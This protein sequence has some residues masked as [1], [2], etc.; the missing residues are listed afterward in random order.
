[1]ILSSFDLLFL[2]QITSSIATFMVTSLNVYGY[3]YN[4]DHNSTGEN[5]LSGENAALIYFS[6]CLAHMIWFWLTFVINMTAFGHHFLL[7]RAIHIRFDETKKDLEY[8]ILSEASSATKPEHI[9][10]LITKHYYV[11]EM[12]KQANRHLKV[13]LFIFYTIFAPHLCL[14][15]YQIM[16]STNAT[17]QGK[18][19][20][21]FLLILSDFF[22]VYSVSVLSAQITTKSHE[23]YYAM[24][25]VNKFDGLPENVQLQ[26][27]EG[28]KK[29]RDFCLF[30]I[31]FFFAVDALYA[32]H[33][34]H[35]R[36]P[37]DSRLLHPH[38]WT[39]FECKCL[40]DFF[41]FFEGL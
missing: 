32:A 39:Y 17:T 26:V 24:H 6:W 36:R 19:F 20:I 14:M 16:F 2:L 37:D 29:L 31:L 25:G 30:L 1:M 28:E 5:V 23:P 21:G 8:A 12:V 15:I 13:Y 4:D 33:F 27:E 34:E 10:G 11:C 38:R 41:L 7:C 3:L 22:Q 35:R 9:S 18:I 40:S